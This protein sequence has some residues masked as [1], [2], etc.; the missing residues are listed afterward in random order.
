MA[1]PLAVIKC[2]REWCRD[3]AQFC[4]RL[5]SQEFHLVD[6]SRTLVSKGLVDTEGKESPVHPKVPG[7]VAKSEQDAL[8]LKPR[9]CRTLSFPEVSCEPERENPA[10]TGTSSDLRGVQE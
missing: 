4:G 1:D 9:D 5:G 10:A 3:Q 7:S 8:I 6:P 2:I